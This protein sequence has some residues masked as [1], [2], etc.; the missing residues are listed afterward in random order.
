MRFIRNKRLLIAL[1][2]AILLLLVGAGLG[3][4]SKLYKSN[5][6]AAYLDERTLNFVRP[7]LRFQISKVDVGSDGV[8]K[9]YFKITDTVGAG[10]DRAGITTPGVVNSSFVL[11]RI[12]KGASQYLSYTVRTQTSPSSGKSAIQAG[13]DTGGTYTLV[14]E[15]EYVYTFGTKLPADVDRSVTH[16]VLIYGNRNLSAFDLGTNYAD[17]VFSWVPNGSPLTVTRDVIKT[18]TCNKCHVDLGF[19]GG[20]RKSMEGCVMCHQPQTIDPDTGNTVDMVVM[21]HKIH[22]GANLPS[23][24]GGKDY[25]IIGNANSVNCYGKI[26]FPAGPNTCSSCHITTATG[27]TRAAQADAHL[28]NPTRAACGACHD[29]VD[30]ASGRGHVAGP[31][32]S[33]NLCANCHIP[34]GELDFDASIMGAHYIPTLAPSLP[35]PRIDILTIDDG[36]AGR[37]PRV[38]FTL[39]DKDGNIVKPADMTSLNLLLAGP[40]SDYAT[41]VSETA[42]AAQDL[43]GGRFAY[44]FNATIP[45]D[46]KG[47]F[48]IGSEGYRNTVLSPGTTKE[49]TVRDA[50]LN[51]T[52]TFS[53]DGKPVENRRQIVSLD[54]C[55]GCHGFLSLHGSNRNQIEQCVLCHNP[56]TT[57]TSRRAAAQ[58]PPESVNFSTMIHRIHAGEE[59]TRDYTIIGFGGSLNNFN[60]VGY[61]GILSNCASCHVGTSHQLPLKDNLLQVTDPRGFIPKVNPETNACLGCHA[62]RAAASHALANTTALGES[63]S[64][65]HGVNGDFSVARVHAR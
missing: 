6:K 17:T 27:A 38:T 49:Q 34:Q 11:A 36:V 2:A 59:Q 53:V 16:S 3:A 1:G 50:I 22:M 26:E 23:V 20:S 5:D 63:C 57:D 18:A 10:L 19:H 62:S 61:P 41:Y 33:D 65:C 30:F 4:P 51:V 14:A 56:N 60:E 47:S 42:R 29:D 45:A 54:K 28:K 55:N 7:G 9:A 39:K 8:V 52:R 12:P 15:G 35:Q 43:G 58:N 48:T 64:T 31:Q 13:A 46:A 25:C 44:T 32:V 24:A 37:K 21:A 40:T